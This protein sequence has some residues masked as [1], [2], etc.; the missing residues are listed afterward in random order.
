MGAVV[1]SKYNFSPRGSSLE[2]N[3]VRHTGQGLVALVKTIRSAKNTKTRTY[4]RFATFHDDN[5]LTHY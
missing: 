5:A 3:L 2:S 4:V 1:T